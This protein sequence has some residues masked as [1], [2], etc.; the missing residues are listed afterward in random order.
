[1]TQKEIIDGG[2]IIAEFMGLEDWGGRFVVSYEPIDSREPKDLFYHSSWDWLMPVVEKISRI[3]TNGKE[4]IHNGED[5]YLETY[6][7]RTFGIVNSETNKFMVR[8]N[9]FGLH[10]SNSLIKATFEA[11]IEF[12]IWH[13]EKPF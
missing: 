6:H 3:S 7:L 9:R 4:I 5:S 13:K 2:K 11:V 12:I 8:I 10:Q 1:M